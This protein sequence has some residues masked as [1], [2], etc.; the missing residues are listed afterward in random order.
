MYDVTEL[1]DS[2][3]DVV[4][5]LVTLK[6]HNIDLSL[7]DNNDEGILAKIRTGESGIQININLR[8]D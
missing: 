4:Q 1:S 6:L 3:L 5:Q 2:L 7:V 8:E